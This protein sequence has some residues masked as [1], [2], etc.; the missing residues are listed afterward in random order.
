MFQKE[1][2]AFIQHLRVSVL[3]KVLGYNLKSCK[4]LSGKAQIQRLGDISSLKDNTNKKH[5]LDGETMNF[6]SW[7]LYTSLSELSESTILI[8]ALLNNMMWPDGDN[9]SDTST[10]FFKTMI[11]ESDKKKQL[12]CELIALE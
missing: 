8:G 12:L 7:K 6:S 11:Y 1:L 4:L 2:G 9:S 5:A 10:E 3:V